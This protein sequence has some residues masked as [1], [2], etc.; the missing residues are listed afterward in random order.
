MDVRYAGG[1]YLTDLE[2]PAET[3]WIVE[4][5]ASR[6]G[7]PRTSESWLI[8]TFVVSL[9]F[10]KVKGRGESRKLYP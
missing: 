5:L 1:L 8:D 10:I 4:S 6:T 9:L 3:S 7:S 2:V